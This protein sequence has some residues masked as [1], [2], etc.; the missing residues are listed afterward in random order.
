MRGVGS[1][2]DYGRNGL[3]GVL[4]VGFKEGTES[5]YWVLKCLA[6]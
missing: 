5:L 4:G 2:K 3:G 6:L 1:G